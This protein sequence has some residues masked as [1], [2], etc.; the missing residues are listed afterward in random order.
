[1]AEQLREL[2]RR[3][4]LAL[5]ETT[6]SSDPNPAHSAFK[7]RDKTFCWFLN[8]HH[9]DGRIALVMKGLPGGQGVLVDAD[10]A[11]FFVPPYVGH[12]GWIGL[13]LDLP[14]VDWDQVEMLLSEA[15]RA[16]APK[17]LAA[18]LAG[19]ATASRP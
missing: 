17:R 13:R 9:A 4:A 6:E 1:M 14:D 2:T 10:P 8:N 5:P 19:A 7:V 11:R 16:T 3:I 12:K 15:W 18:R